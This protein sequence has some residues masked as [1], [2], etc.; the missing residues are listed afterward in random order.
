MINV[1]N[2]AQLLDMIRGAKQN[3]LL[4][5]S[6]VDELNVFPVPDGDTGTN[7]GLTIT[8]TVNEA[9]TVGDKDVAAIARYRGEDL[10]E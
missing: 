9:E 5:K 8:A 2:G 4:N 1:L 6:T 7:M 10:H 3:L